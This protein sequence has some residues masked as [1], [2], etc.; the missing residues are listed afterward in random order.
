MTS[1]EKALLAGAI[2]AGVASAYAVADPTH[3]EL[4]AELDALEAQLSA[5]RGPT[6]ADVDRV[7]SD[8]LKDAN[9]R[10]KLLAVEGLTAGWDNGFRIGSADGNYLLQPG[11]L[12]Q[13]GYVANYRKEGKSNGN[14][15]LQDGFELRRMQLIFTGNAI[16]PDLTY[17]FMWNSSSGSGSPVLR[18]AWLQYKFAKNMVFRFGQFRDIAWHEETTIDYK[19]LAADRSVVNG[20]IGGT[21]A[22][23]VQGIML[24]YT[25]DAL[26]AQVAFH[27][28]ANS[29]NT[30]F[31]NS[32]TVASQAPGDTD[33]GVSGR[34]EYFVMGKDAR[35]QYEDFTALNNKEDLLVFGGGFDWTQSG[36]NDAIFHTLDVQY[37]NTGGLGLYA[38]YLAVDRQGAGDGYDWGALLQGSYLFGKNMEAFGR[39]SYTKLDD[40]AP[41]FDENVHEI[42]IGLNHYYSGHNAK[43]TIEASYLPNGSP[44]NLGQLD[45]LASEEDQ[46]IIRGQFQLLL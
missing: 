45:V 24:G 33:F 42:T 31:E 17:R 1:R 43:V 26:T 22:D 11:V 19:Q 30:T 4:K 8:V 13:I 12:A 7:V 25:E 16:T 44:T 2:V 36:A 29:K 34:V 39:Y 38:A 23:R 5:E 40:P 9:D 21:N 20:L 32:P 14:D 10:S 18:D 3:A 37:E 6:S 41:G 27:D 15:D 46:I 35:K 28:G